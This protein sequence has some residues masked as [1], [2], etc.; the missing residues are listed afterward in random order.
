LRRITAYTLVGLSIILVITAVTIPTRA[1]D[2]TNVGVRLKDTATYKLSSTF[3]Y[4]GSH[5]FVWGIVGPTTYINVTQSY[6]NGTLDKYQSIG[7]FTSFGV[8]LVAGNLSVGDLLWNGAYSPTV[9][10]TDTMTAGGVSRIVNIANNRSYP[11]F[12]MD[13]F[14]FDKQTGLL[15]QGNIWTLAAGWRNFTLISTTAWSP[16][17]QGEGTLGLTTIALAGGVGVTALIVGF[18]VGR[19]GKRKK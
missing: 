3:G 5:I 11:P 19:S 17:V 1:A 16:S 4:N 13:R 7:D 2:Y 10:R 12:A 14:I 6:P 18:F 15:I 8:Y 9:A